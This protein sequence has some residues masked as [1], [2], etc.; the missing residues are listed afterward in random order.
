MTPVQT[1]DESGPI[2][3]IRAEKNI[4]FIHFFIRHKFSNYQS[5]ANFENFFMGFKMRHTRDSHQDF[6]F[7]YQLPG[8]VERKAFFV[9]EMECNMKSWYYTCGLLG[10]LWPYSLWVERKI[11]RFNV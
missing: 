10:L 1:K 9:G 7:G 5:Q 2:D 8:L 11:S 6:T 3:Q 4:V